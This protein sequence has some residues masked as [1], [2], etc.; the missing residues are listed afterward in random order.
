MNEVNS[1]FLREQI[2]RKK[3]KQVSRMTDT[4]YALNKDMLNNMRNEQHA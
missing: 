3:G 2:D 1:Q 4:E